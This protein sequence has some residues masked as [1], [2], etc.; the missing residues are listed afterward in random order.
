VHKG[1]EEEEVKLQSR[2]FAIDDKE[3]GGR[4]DTCTRTYCV[5]GIVSRRRVQDEMRGNFL[6][7]MHM[8]YN[9]PLLAQFDAIL[10]I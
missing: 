10:Y 7:R 2:V 4:Y 5:Y 3:E 9:A 8:H 1:H 6:K